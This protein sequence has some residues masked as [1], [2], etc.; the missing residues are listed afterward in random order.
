VLLAGPGVRSTALA[1]A[2]LSLVA[3]AVVLAEP[4]FSSQQRLAKR[5]GRASAGRGRPDPV[6]GC[7]RALQPPY[8]T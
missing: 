6:A 8:T 4:F 3:L 7:S 2:L 1:G 5:T